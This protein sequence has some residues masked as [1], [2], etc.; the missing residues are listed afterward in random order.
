[1]SGDISVPS[2][3]SVRENDFRR[4]QSWLH[5]CLSPCPLLFLAMIRRDIAPAASTSRSRGTSTRRIVARCGAKCAL[6]AVATGAMRVVAAEPAEP[7]SRPA[8]PPQLEYNA[9]YASSSACRD[10]HADQ[11]ASWHRTFHRTMTQTAAPG[12]FV[13]RFDGTQI[14]S[15]GLRYRVFQRGDEYCAEMPD[16]DAMV[17]S[18]RTYEMELR[19]NGRAAPPLWHD[20]PLVERRVVMST[21]SHHYQTYWVE[22][23]RYP[24]TLVTLPLVYL[25]GD[26]RWIPREAAFMYPPGPRRMVTV[27]NDHCIKCHSTGPVPSPFARVDQQGRRVL[28]TGFHTRVGEMGIA[29]EA[30][31]GP[32]QEHVRMRV[33]AQRDERATSAVVPLPNDP[34]IQPEHLG[35]HRRTSYVCGQCHGVYVLTDEQGVRYRDHGNDYVPGDDLLAKRKYLFPPQPPE[36][37]P[38]DKSRQEALDEYSANRGFFGERY[39][40]NGLVLAA[41]REFSALAVSRCYTKGTISCLSCHSMHDSEPNDQLKANM[42]TNAACTQCHSQTQYT[43]DIAEHT[44]HGP[45]STGSDCL[46]CHM[47]RTT[48]ALFTAI[49]NHQIASPDL[50]GSVQHG[51]PNACNLCHL[52]KTLGWTQ[53][54]LAD[55]YG[56]E[57]HLLTSQQEKISA[58][59]VWMLQGHAA[60]RVIVAWHFGWPPAQV[61]SGADWLAPF[62]SRLLADPYGVV[63]YVAARSLKTLPEFAQF[64][65]DFLAAD[66]ALAQASKRATQHWNN[67]RGGPPSRTGVQ[68]LLTK[69]GDVAEEVVWWLLQHR[70]NRPVTIQE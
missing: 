19:R 43:T 21:G 39:W 51:V 2:A 24:G 9:H 41:G 46:N 57:K 8:L 18:Q 49:R 67:R 16:P 35:D 7:S 29:C 6:M 31:H 48:Y 14:D 64:D 38:D 59:L 45:A 22:S 61:A 56:Y 13:G 4:G 23:V 54:R 10:C 33:A 28:E 17:N 62:V 20:I 44:H 50:K 5:W 42:H 40:D 11:Y 12:R 47:P 63:R 32:A 60:Q 58:A 34:I 52:D 53:D 55:W 70:D 1:M 3:E 66:D 68:V 30:C 36:F 27:W 69:N 25:I 15:Y 65:Y 26:Q 37:Y